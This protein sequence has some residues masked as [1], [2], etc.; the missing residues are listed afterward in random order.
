LP[1]EVYDN[2]DFSEFK[3]MYRQAI[4]YGETVTCA[5]GVCGDRHIVTL[6]GDDGEIRAIMELVK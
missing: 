2:T 3:I 6:K 5:Y 4:K 1:D